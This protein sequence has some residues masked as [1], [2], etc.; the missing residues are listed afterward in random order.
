MVDKHNEYSQGVYI[1]LKK[2]PKEL[3]RRDV[4]DMTGQSEKKVSKIEGQRM[5]VTKKEI[6]VG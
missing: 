1:S 2:Q 5:M 4:G 3:T 6:G